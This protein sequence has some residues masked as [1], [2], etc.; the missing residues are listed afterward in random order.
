MQ[1]ASLA[2]VN[3]LAA[4]SHNHT[5][6]QYHLSTYP[7]ITAL[8]QLD[9]CRMQA[10]VPHASA[11]SFIHSCYTCSRSSFEQRQPIPNP[12]KLG[13]TDAFVQQYI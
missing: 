1:A 8:D 7:W 2:V 12:R 3:V 4:Y 10:M 13:A 6:E 9:L 5:A 11:A